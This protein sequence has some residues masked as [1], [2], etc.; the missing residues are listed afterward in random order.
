MDNYNNLIKNIKKSLGIGNIFYKEIGDKHGENNFYVLKRVINPF[1]NDLYVQC[2]SEVFYIGFETDISVSYK[3]KYSISDNTISNL[4]KEIFIELVNLH[5]DEIYKKLNNFNYEIKA[6][7]IVDGEKLNF[8][9]SVEEL[10]HIIAKVISNHDGLYKIDN[11][12]LITENSTL[13]NLS[14]LEAQNDILN[15]IRFS[16]ITSIEYND[17]VEAHQ[18]KKPNLPLLII[19]TD[20]GRLEFN[21]TDYCCGCTFLEDGLEDLE[22]MIGEEILSIESVSNRNKVPFTDFTWD[23]YTFYKIETRNHSCTLRFYEGSNYGCY[24]DVKY[25]DIKEG[26]DA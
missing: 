6:S 1:L 11:L 23:V 15:K 4:A 5:Y 24:V 14:V 7:H 2:N 20:T 21:H 12:N 13:E 9:V 8:I 25:R 16:K 26:S 18:L 10:D 17:D 19:E 22:L 3:F